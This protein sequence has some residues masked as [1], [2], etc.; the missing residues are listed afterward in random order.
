MACRTCDILA[1]WGGTCGMGSR[2]VVHGGALALGASARTWVSSSRSFAPSLKVARR[3]R[4]SCYVLADLSRKS[5]RE[6]H[7]P[8]CGLHRLHG[9][10][11]FGFSGGT[12]W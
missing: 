1:S 11:L 10:G 2:G 4:S 8:S 9:I 6:T 7:Y 12:S 5:G 3:S